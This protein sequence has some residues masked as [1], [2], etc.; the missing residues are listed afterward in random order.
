[1]FT[2]FGQFI[3]AWLAVG[4]TGG[5]LV[6]SIVEDYIYGDFTVGR[7]TVKM[8]LVALCAVMLYVL[9]MMI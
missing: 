3:L 6:F 5:C 9:V 2:F 1:M 4:F 8:L 7:F